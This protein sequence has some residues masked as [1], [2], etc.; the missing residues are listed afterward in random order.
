MSYSA[1]QKTIRDL[2]NSQLYRI[3]RNQRKYVWVKDNWEDLYLDLEY[4]IKNKVNHFIGSIV[5]L[6]D[7]EKVAGLP[8]FTVIDGQQRIFTLTIF[9]SAIMFSM[10]KHELQN[11][12]FGTE[13]YLFAKDDKNEIHNIFSSSYHLGLEKI[14]LGLSDLDFS[15]ENQLTSF[16]NINV[17]DKKRDKPII[18]AFTYFFEKIEF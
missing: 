7:K 17:T 8:Q 6:K 18:D 3:P 10:K 16:I 11:D 4:A 1:E 14:L 12:Y 13:K 9:L 5:L 15:K 2:F